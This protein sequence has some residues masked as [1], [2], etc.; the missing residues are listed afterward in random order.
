MTLF[1]VIAAAPL[2]RLIRKIVSGTAEQIW[3]S[4]GSDR[5]LKEHRSIKPDF[6]LLDIDSSHENAISAITKMRSMFPASRIVAIT[7]YDEPDLQQSVHAAGAD[8][9]LAKENLLQ[10]SRLLRWPA[11]KK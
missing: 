8:A 1:I 2:R 7:S 6:V 5:M 10:L 11:R 4:E 3:E 9:C